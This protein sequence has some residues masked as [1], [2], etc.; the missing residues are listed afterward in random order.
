MIV[1]SVIL[2][3]LVFLMS[4]TSGMFTSKIT[5][6]TYF[7]NAEGLRSGQPVDLQGVPVGNVTAVRVVTNRPLTPVQVTLRIIRRYAPLVHKDT[8][9]VVR[10]AGVLGESF[11]DLDSKQAKKPPVDDGDE[12]PSFN[13]PGI[14]DVVRSSQTTLQNMDVLVKRLD[15]IVAQV[16]TGKGSLGQIISDPTLINKANGI[17]NQIQ[18]ML[19]DVNNGRGTI[20]K[21]FSDDSLYKKANAE[22]DKLDRIIDDLNAGKGTAGKFLKDEAL[23]NN[24]NQT[25]AKANQLM[26]DVNEGKGALGTLAKDEE[27]ARKLRNTM[28]KLSS[29]ADQIESGQGSVGLLIKNPS[30][31]NNT[32]QLLIE[33]RQLMKAVRENPKKYLTI[34]FRIF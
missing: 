12:L 13:A 2:A 23:Y 3:I 8:T 25:I 24:A 26:A 21:L 34:H 14:E 15:R 5:L 19:N 17:L 33:T 30:V 10:T 7:D 28:N 22:I 1:A 18:G 9:A 16:E 11:I 31:Y 4:G 27:F 6:V 29:V 32:D 20:G